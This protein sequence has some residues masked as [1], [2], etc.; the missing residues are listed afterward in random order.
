[1]KLQA[2]FIVKPPA[3]LFIVDPDVPESPLTK[4]GEPFTVTVFIP[5]RIAVV[6]L[7]FGGDGLRED[8]DTLRQS[9]GTERTR[10]PVFESDIFCRDF[11]V[12]DNEKVGDFLYFGVP[13]AF[14]E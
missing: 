7:A 5:Q 8:I 14:A 4:N 10:T 1:M 13:D 11:F 12:S 6:K 9:L 3:R 2:I